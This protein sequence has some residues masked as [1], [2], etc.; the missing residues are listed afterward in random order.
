MLN[1]MKRT[2]TISNAYMYVLF[3]YSLA[4]ILLYGGCIASQPSKVMLRLPTSLNNV[5]Q[6]VGMFPDSVTTGLM[7]FAFV[8]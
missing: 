8:L 3:S 4:L 7:A 1:V 6:L 5:P 2:F